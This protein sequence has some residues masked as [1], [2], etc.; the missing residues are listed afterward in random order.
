MGE[1]SEDSSSVA[2]RSRRHKLFAPTK[3]EVTSQLRRSFGE[4]CTSSAGSGCRG[5]E[6]LR[7]LTSVIVL[8][9]Q[10]LFVGCAQ[11]SQAQTFCTHESRSHK[12]APQENRR[13]L[14][15]LCSPSP[16]IIASRRLLAR[17]EN[18]IPQSRRDAGRREEARIVEQGL[19]GL[20]SLH[21]IL[22]RL[23]SQTRQKLH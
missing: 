22:A 3:A 17:R 19:E 8:T 2:L 14:H 6:A 5:R 18:I 9:V 15:I 10:G 11:K 16:P 20:N 21:H 7:K 1:N 13:K 12:S 23:R 4:N